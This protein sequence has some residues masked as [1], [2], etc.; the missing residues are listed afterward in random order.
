MKRIL[1]AVGLTVLCVIFALLTRAGVSRFFPGLYG[2]VY[3]VQVVPQVEKQPPGP[4]GIAPGPIL[5]ER[6]TAAPQGEELYATGAIISSTRA[7]VQMSD[8]SVR[9]LEDRVPSSFTA[10]PFAGKS[11][12]QFVTRT[13]AIIDGKR[14]FYRPRTQANPSL[15]GG[16]RL[17]LAAGL[18]K[19]KSYFEGVPPTSAQ[20]PITHENEGSLGQGEAKALGPGA[21]P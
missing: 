3:P 11:V 16:D 14:Y 8:G 1:F 15:Q 13:S 5:V 7:I 12:V 20:A 2:R 19:A 4:S 9:T 10:T 6:P 17:S 21:G 18:G